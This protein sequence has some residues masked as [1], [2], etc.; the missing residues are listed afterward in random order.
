MSKKGTV[1]N[2][3]ADVETYRRHFNGFCFTA[4]LLVL[5]QVLFSQNIKPNTTRSTKAFPTGFV[6]DVLVSRSGF[7]G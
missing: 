6:T 7:V 2:N 4:L 3:H 5:P 1:F